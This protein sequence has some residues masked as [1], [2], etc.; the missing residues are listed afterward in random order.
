[1]A[2]FVLLSRLGRHDDVEAGLNM[3]QLDVHAVHD[4]VTPRVVYQVGIVVDF[5]LSAW[6]LNVEFFL[7][8]IN[9]VLVWIGQLLQLVLLREDLV[10]AIGY[11]VGQL[12]MDLEDHRAL[13]WNRR[14]RQSIRNLHDEVWVVASNRG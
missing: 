8:S 14:H 2:S 9:L 10:V 5:Y 13:V 3:L 7:K 12:G 4:W 1:M 6:S 11:V